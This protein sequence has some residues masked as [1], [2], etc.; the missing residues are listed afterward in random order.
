[1]RTQRWPRCHYFHIQHHHG[2]GWEAE[3]LN[4]P[5]PT[6]LPADTHWEHLKQ[7][8][9]VNLRKSSR[10]LR[11]EEYPTRSGKHCA[12]QMFYRPF[13]VL[14]GTFL[15]PA[16]RNKEFWVFLTLANACWLLGGRYGEIEYKYFNT[17]I[18]RFQHKYFQSLWALGLCI[19]IKSH[20]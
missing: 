17:S 18:L 11:K 12:W 1:M 20:F 10:K 8:N 16:W 2:L 3:M 6:E 19:K 13:G 9:P 7:N 15:A 5:R 4:W 14:W